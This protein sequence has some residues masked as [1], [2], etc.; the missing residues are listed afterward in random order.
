MTIILKF[1]AL[2]LKRDKYFSTSEIGLTTL[3]NMDLKSTGFSTLKFRKIGKI[4]LKGSKRRN[5]ILLI[6]RW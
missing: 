6:Q 5:L 4:K 3:P 1:E 2:I